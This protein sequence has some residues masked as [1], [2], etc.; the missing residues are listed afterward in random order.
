MK[1]RKGHLLGFVFALLAVAGCDR[2]SADVHCGDTGNAVVI[3]GPILAYLSQAR[4]LHHEASLHESA[5]KIDAALASL[6]RLVAAPKP[7]AGM[8]VPEVEEVLADAYARMAELELSQSALDRAAA[9]VDLGL[10]HASGDTYFRGH[11]FEIRG[12]IEE[13]RSRA[14]AD[15]GVGN[16]DAAEAARKRALVALEEAIGIQERVIKNA[17]SDGGAP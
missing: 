3:D 8:P 17:L 1:A 13:A 4:A 12:L 5:G 9:N 10:A 14:L 6:G 2:K 11:L 16:K 15:G 7:H